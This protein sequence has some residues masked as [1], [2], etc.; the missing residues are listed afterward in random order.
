M[1][2][3]K[4]WLFPGLTLAEDGT[5]QA[6]ED[7]ATK[8]ESVENGAG[9]GVDAAGQKELFVS[10]EHQMMEE[11]KP[12]ILEQAKEEFVDQSDYVSDS[13]FPQIVA[14]C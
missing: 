4:S 5:V 3:I 10:D 8:M 12:K 7:V 11:D 2:S 1:R 14:E 13:Y 9:I 6:I